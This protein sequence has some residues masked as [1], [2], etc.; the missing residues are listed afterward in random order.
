[1]FMSKCIVLEYLI[2]LYLYYSMSPVQRWVIVNRLLQAVEGQR[3]W[4][5]AVA[6]AAAG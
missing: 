3:F 5:V 6:A 2:R 4:A 1:M